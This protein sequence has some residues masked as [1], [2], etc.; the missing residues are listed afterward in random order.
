MPSFD[1]DSLTPNDRPREVAKILA[2]GMFR[3]YLLSLRMLQPIALQ[4]GWRTRRKKWTRVRN[5]SSRDSR[6]RSRLPSL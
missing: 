2:P 4:P 5:G 1:D 6:R 3:K